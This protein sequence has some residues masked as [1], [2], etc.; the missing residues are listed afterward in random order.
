MSEWQPINTAP[1]DG[2]KI[3]AFCQPRHIE[4]GAPMSFN[5]I[6]VVWWRGDR[7]PFIDSL[8]KW[9]HSQNDSAAEPTH[10]MP[11]PPPPALIASH[12]DREG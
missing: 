7:R 11:L 6:G 12:Q 10:W 2:T 4:T 1:K 8:W 5:Y 3:L 9:R